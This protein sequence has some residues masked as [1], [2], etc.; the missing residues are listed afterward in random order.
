MEDPFHLSFGELENVHLQWER[1]R[2]VFWSAIATRAELANGVSNLPFLQTRAFPGRPH[3]FKRRRTAQCTDGVE[4]SPETHPGWITDERTRNLDAGGEDGE[5]P[6]FGRSRPG[7]EQPL[8]LHVG[9]TVLSFSHGHRFFAAVS[10][11]LVMTAVQCMPS[12]P[13]HSAYMEHAKDAR[14]RLACVTRERGPG[15]DE[16]RGVRSQLPTRRTLGAIDRRVPLC[17]FFPSTPDERA[18]L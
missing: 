1:K 5:A 10:K 14:E 16:L 6:E 11:T 4:H 7:R 9:P 17:F 13:M 8:S 12:H 15:Y 2:H 3:P 18:E